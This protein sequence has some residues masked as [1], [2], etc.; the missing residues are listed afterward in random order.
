[1]KRYAVLC[2]STASG[3][4]AGLGKTSCCLEATI[5]CATCCGP[6]SRVTPSGVCVW[7]RVRGRGGMEGG[8]AKRGGMVGGKGRG[9][10]GAME[11]GYER[12][13]G[14]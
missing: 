10:V 12:G 4:T 13:R 7:R 2:T 14:G 5:F 1:M 9:R 11:E 6:L 3:L 8:W